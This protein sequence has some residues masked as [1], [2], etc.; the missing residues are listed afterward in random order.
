MVWP[1]ADFTRRPGVAVFRRD[2][3]ELSPRCRFTCAADRTRKA[4]DLLHIEDRVAFHAVDFAV[5]FLAARAI[6]LGA[7]VSA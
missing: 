4:V 7:M 5:G 2:G 6:G 3:D 1:E